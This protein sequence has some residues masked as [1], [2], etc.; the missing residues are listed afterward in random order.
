MKANDRFNIPSA[1]GRQDARGGDVERLQRFAH[2]LGSRLT[3]EQLASALEEWEL[4][5]ESRGWPLPNI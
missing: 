2:I 4:E 3:P 5:C 1:A